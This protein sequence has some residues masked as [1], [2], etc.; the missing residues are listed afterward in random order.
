MISIET[1]IREA[2]A[3]L[4]TGVGDL[5]RLAELRTHPA[6][7]SADPTDVATVL[8]RL[9]N[10]DSLSGRVMLAPIS[11]RKGLTE[12]DRHHAIPAPMGEWFHLIAIE[13]PEESVQSRRPAKRER[14]LSFPMQDMLLYVARHGRAHNYGTTARALVKRDLITGARL[15]ANL[16][17]LLA[18]AQLTEGG[19][20][21]LLLHAP[22]VAATAVHRAELSAHEYNDQFRELDRAKAERTRAMLAAGPEA[23]WYG[24]R[25]STTARTDEDV[26]MAHQRFGP[27]TGLVAAR[28]GIVSAIYAERVRWDL[29]QRRHGYDN[30]YVIARLDKIA[31]GF[32]AD[33]NALSVTVD[34]LNFSLWTDDHPT[35][36]ANAEAEA[37]AEETE[38]AALRLPVCTSVITD[39]GHGITGRVLYH[40]TDSIVRVRLHN[41]LPLQPQWATCQRSSLVT[42]ADLWADVAS[43][44]EVHD[45]AFYVR[46]GAYVAEDPYSRSIAWSEHLSPNASSAE[47]YAAHE[48][49]DV[50]VTRPI[51][52]AMLASYG[53]YSNSTTYDASNYRV[54]CRTYV[55]GQTDPWLYEVGTNERDGLGIAVRIGDSRWN[56]DQVRELAN[57]VRGLADYPVLDEMDLSEYESELTEQWWESGGES[58]AHSEIDSRLAETGA[59]DSNGEPYTWDTAQLSEE[60]VSDNGLSSLDRDDMIRDLFLHYGDMSATFEPQ[61]ATEM[62]CTD[63]EATA[64]HITRTLF[65]PVPHVGRIDAHSGA[66]GTT[67]PASWEYAS[68]GEAESGRC[69]AC[70]R[71]I[72]IEWNTRETWAALDASRERTIPFNV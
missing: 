36:A 10:V 57:M 20:Q 61:S 12:Q 15:F 23:H 55:D 8:R 58:D 42:T 5:V 19:W 50:G 35:V 31:E 24:V 56:I 70:D 16:S 25:N 41:P 51:M 11:N 9:H 40:Q 71:P 18:S 47:Y 39:Y 46:D 49:I 13:A 38:R 54:L 21:W 33:P 45:R 67:C 29:D 4:A 60:F 66:D 63:F 52:F 28:S 14:P 59:L 6:L 72:A 27:W 62:Y 26:A 32:S 7:A 34:G 64:E 17:G 65:A 3:A 43:Y 2:Y 69:L 44:A 22:E 48:G 1:M 37:Y 53:D 30:T 68:V